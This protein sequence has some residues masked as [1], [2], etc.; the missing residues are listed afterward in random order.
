MRIFVS[1]TFV[2][3]RAERD[4][5]AEALRRAQLVPWGMELFV[6][7]PS[8]PLD[9]CLEQLRLSDA[10]VLIIGFKAGSII[11]E[12]PGLTY[13][14]AEFQLAQQLGRPVFAFFKTE[15]GVPLNKE[16]DG[17]KKKALD[18]FRSAV[19]SA[20]ITPAY[21][22]TP[23]R[24]EVE[25][26][27]AM[28]KWNAEG[29]PGS[30]L[31]FSTPSEFFAPFES[32]EPRLF[33]FKQTLRGRDAQLGA[34]DGF[35]ADPGPVVGVL[36]GRG[37]IGKSKVLRDWVQTVNNRIVLYVREDAEWHAEAAKEIPVGDVLIV[38]DD[39]H[40]FDFLGKLLLLARNLRQR[41]NVK[42]LLGT[43]PSGLGQVDALL[44]VR[45]D[46]AEIL[47]FPQ[48][49]RMPQQGVRQLAAEVLGPAHAQYAQ[50][51]A[52]VSADTPLVTVVGGRLIARGDI[53]PAL[54]ANEEDFRHQV[55]DRFT[56]EYEQ[57]LPAGA[58][59]WKSL[60]H[61]IAAVSPVSPAAAQFIDPAVQILGVRPDQVRS[62]ID[63]LEQRG[64]LLRGGRLIRI[65]PDLLSD[66]LLEGAC[67]TGAG[68]STG[69]SDLM[70][71]TF[72]STYLSNLLRNLGELDWRITQR[73]NPDEA[74]RLLD[75]IW[76]EIGRA[77]DAGDASVRVQLLKSLTG[78]APFQPARVLR[79]I[80]H[81]IENEAVKLQVWSDFAMTQEHVLREIPPLLRGIS[82]HLE[83]IEEAAEILWRLA[84]SDTRAPHQ[85]ADHAQRVLEEMADYGR[86]KPVRYNDWM[87]DFAARKSTNPR[88]F[89]GKFTP[90]SIVDKLLEK[91]GEF[92]ESE[93]HTIS[94]GKFGLYYPAVRPVREKALGIIEACLNSDDP[95]IALRATASV[96]RVLSGFPPSFRQITDDE[97]KWQIDERLAALGIVENRLNKETPTPLLR[98][99]R[100]VLRR[101]RPHVKD[102]P[103]VDR[104]DGL[105]ANIP[106]SD[107]LVIFDAF[108]T[109]EWDHDVFYED[110]EEANRS[111]KELISRGVAAF[112]K[113]F[114]DGQ[115]Q[116]EGLV[117]LVTDAEAC[118]ISLTNEPYSFIEEL[119]APDFVE[120]FLRYAMS[121]PHPLLAQMVAIPLRWLRQR[122]LARYRRVGIEA[123]THKN[124]LLAYG[125]ANAVSYGPNLNEPLAEDAA[126][127]RELAKHP[128]PLVRHLTFTGIRRL[129]HSHAYELA[130]I[131]MLLGS[132]IGDDERMAEE[133]CGAVD[134]AGIKKEHLSEAQIRQLLDKLVMTKTI[135]EHHIGRFLAWVGEH[136]P[137][138]LFEFTLRRLD[139]DAEIEKG[140]DKIAGYTPIPHSRFGNAFRPLQNGPQY[141]YFLEQVAARLTT[142]PKQ[143]FWL[144]GLFW[145]IGSIDATTLG[146][147]DGLL[148]RD[149]KDFVRGALQLLEGAPPEL[150]LS[151]PLFAVHVIEESRRVDPQFGTA[152]E[153][154]LVGNTQSGAFNRTPGQ[155]SPKYAS[156]K[157]R[158]GALRDGF[159]PGIYGASA[160]HAN[161]RRRTGMA[162]SRTPAGR[163]NE[164]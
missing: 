117:Q 139:R 10:V 16:V 53:P 131:E 154:I 50:A 20:Q 72:Q 73:R 89:E 88:E 101:S 149:D 68:D 1:S 82:Y 56:A 104:I 163:G 135:E 33:D 17:P 156:L 93:G 13:T 136:F 57:L 111:R 3:L 22:D 102:N 115:Q 85:Y 45:F 7:E 77:F 134:Y 140:D 2:D 92:T 119:C 128:S 24:L 96:A 100:S 146:V 4:A 83:H 129:G 26:L 124:A 109:G 60:L 8:S 43:R 133:M 70:F 120:A 37:G 29:R 15:G 155:P 48:L 28:E 113:R 86:Y 108:S 23:D 107:D 151:H 160:L 34:L 81:A 144:R 9:V 12:S 99:L 42:L 55:F 97:V 76:D 79:L 126:I 141:Q 116:V 153:S 106:Q 30:R 125:A 143:F 80:H 31:V 150:A 61:L 74:T 67:L 25:L 65:V 51:L 105:L 69:F 148:H 138:A 118:G 11:P 103:L 27:L 84:K 36:S 123:A 54:L 147:I 162:G 14:G 47:R 122:D 78:A 21:F 18:D 40:R 94:L 75:G 142:Q 130:A 32:D 164:F 110:L 157:E 158:S 59:D 64:L 49:E 90:L 114:A 161:M 19:T 121:D 38:A 145:E 6:S 91:E 35:L 137:P 98:Q 5:A 41:Q 132:E 58:V 87:A 44:S 112:R 62:A 46:P 152:A 159:A 127:L 63:L 71:Q 39:A 66:F 95:K 52:A